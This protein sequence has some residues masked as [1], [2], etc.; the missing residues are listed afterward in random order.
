MKYSLIL[1]ALYLVCCQKAN[2]TRGSVTD[3]TAPTVTEDVFECNDDTGST[4][5][6]TADTD[7][8]ESFYCGKDPDKSQRKSFCL[9]DPTNYKGK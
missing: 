3:V 8:C 1:I 7:C 2:E 4:L 6:C 9:Y 5:E